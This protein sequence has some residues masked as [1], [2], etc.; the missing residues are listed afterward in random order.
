MDR[1]SLNIAAA[2]AL[3]WICAAGF[4][5]IDLRNTDRHP[6]LVSAKVALKSGDSLVCWLDQDGQMQLSKSHSWEECATGM[7]KL[8]V[9][10]R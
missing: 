8:I 1:T 5:W 2:V 6:H 4:H 3:V 10:T 9:G 7:A